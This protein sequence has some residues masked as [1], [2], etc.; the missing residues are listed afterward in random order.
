VALLLAVSVEFCMVF[1]SADYME[2]GLGLLKADAA[3]TVSLFL[4]GMISGR[5]AASRLVQRFAPVKVV[6]ASN[7]LAAAGFLVYWSAGTPVLGAVGL[8]FTGLG[9]ASLYPL[10]LSMAINASG[11]NSVQAGA[12]ASLASG[13]AI[14]TLPLVLG[15]LADAA[16]IRLAFGV[17]AILLV[18]VFFII[19]LNTRLAANGV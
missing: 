7:V 10:I 8:F 17:V 4:L 2:K 16:G 6:I 1:W 3:Q 14:F 9:V 5:L 12:R 18:G 13:T 19:V 15:R 11:G